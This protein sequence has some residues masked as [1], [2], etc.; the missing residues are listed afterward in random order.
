MTRVH[1]CVLCFRT[2]FNLNVLKTHYLKQHSKTNI[3]KK[4][5]QNGIS[6]KKNSAHG[7][8]RKKQKEIDLSFTFRSR[9]NKSMEKYEIFLPE[10]V[11]FQLEPEKRT[12]PKQCFEINITK[13][14]KSESTLSLNE[15]SG[16][17]YVCKCN[18]NQNFTT[19]EEQSLANL[20]TIKLFVCSICHEQFMLEQTLHTHFNDHMENDLYETVLDMETDYC[21]PEYNCLHPDYETSIM[22]IVNYFFEPYSYFQENS[23]FFLTTCKYCNLSMNLFDHEHH[24]LLHLNN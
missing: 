2:F 14:D 20:C 22:N 24:I 12:D 21:L 13:V 8:L 5:M 7:K 1:S 3:I 6:V 10:S 17:F 16:E 15:K 9:G 23:Q 4:L 11:K 19:E 18:Q